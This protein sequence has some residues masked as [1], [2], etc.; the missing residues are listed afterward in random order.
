MSVLT[1]TLS[2]RLWHD[3]AHQHDL[4]KLLS[5]TK[6]KAR[7][8]LRWT[9]RTSTKPWN[10]ESQDCSGCSGVRWLFKEFR[11]PSQAGRPGMWKVPSNHVLVSRLML[12]HLAV[13]KVVPESLIPLHSCCQEWQELLSP[14]ISG[15]LFGPPWS[16]EEKLNSIHRCSLSIFAHPPW[17]KHSE[18]CMT[19]LIPCS[20]VE[21]HTMR[22][23]LRPR[24]WGHNVIAF[25]IAISILL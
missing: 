14:S 10:Y 6:D 4:A 12:L 9:H 16:R 20:A 3:V 19:F 13:L 5:A 21:N 25:F 2:L 1:D 11:S 15:C 17:G 24:T 23:N 22:T 8:T 7:D 18:Q